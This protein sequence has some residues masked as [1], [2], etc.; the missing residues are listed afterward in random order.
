MP[1]RANWH[2]NLKWHFEWKVG[3]GWEGRKGD[4]RKLLRLKQT[5]ETML[6]DVP[7]MANFQGCKC[8]PECNPDKGIFSAR[9]L[10]AKE[11]QWKISAY[12]E[13]SVSQMALLR[14]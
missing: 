10:A 6:S 13:D 5:V 4:C 9:G 1:L 3:R 8:K 7:F 14:V 11:N 12:L 2:E